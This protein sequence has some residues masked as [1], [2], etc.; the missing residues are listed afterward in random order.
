MA[1]LSVSRLTIASVHFDGDLIAFFL[2]PLAHIGFGDGL[3]PEPSGHANFNLNAA[4]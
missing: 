1:A 3:S 4:G 2:K